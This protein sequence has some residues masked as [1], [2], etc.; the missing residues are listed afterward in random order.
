MKHL[1]FIKRVYIDAEDNDGYRILV[2]RIWPR[3]ISKEKARLS[4]WIKDIAPSTELRK[5]FQH[6]PELF[7]TFKQKYIEEIKQHKDITTK[8]LDVLKEQNITLVYS[9]KDEK[10]N[11]A[12]VLQEFLKNKHISNGKTAN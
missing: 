3:G 12:I 7:N 1:I 4:D 10:Y 5:W 6:K 9:A 11:Q 8:I 2:D